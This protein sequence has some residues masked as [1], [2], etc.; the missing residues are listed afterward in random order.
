[1]IRQIFAAIQ[2]RFCLFA[3]NRGGFDLLA[4][5]CAGTEISEIETGGESPTLGAFT[6]GRRTE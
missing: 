5:N 3:Q 4:E 6:R 1:M 2:N